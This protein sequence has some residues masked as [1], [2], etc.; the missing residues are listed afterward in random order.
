M[1]AAANGTIGSIMIRATN[2]DRSQ[3]WLPKSMI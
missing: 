3:F 1:A 2:R